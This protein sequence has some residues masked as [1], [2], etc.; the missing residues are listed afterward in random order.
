MSH[1]SGQPRDLFQL[2]AV[3]PDELAAIAAAAAGS[4]VARPVAHPAPIAY[5]WGSPATAG[6]WRVDVTS[7]GV[8]ACALF[9][10]LVRHT[11][12]WPVLSHL[13]D[14]ASRAEFISYYPWHYEL[15]VC[16]KSKKAINY[17]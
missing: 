15:D 4:P 1:A 16:S 2:A 17:W 14:E 10:K 5:D 6:L 8:A 3:T 11:R 12:L 7:D 9:V 13:P